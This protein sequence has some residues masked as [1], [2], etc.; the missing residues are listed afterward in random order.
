MSTEP[1]PV[2][3]TPEEAVA[4]LQAAAHVLDV[5]LLGYTTN[6]WES[7]VRL[8]R[9]L[10]RALRRAAQVDANLVTWLYLH[11]EHGKH[12]QVDGVSGTVAIG[13][14]RSKVRWEGP[15]AVRDYVAARITANDGEMPDPDTVIDWVLEVVPATPSTEL[16][17]TPL[18][19]A[20]LDPEDYS[21]SEPGTVSV[22]VLLDT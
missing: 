16:R 21:Q 3:V 4:R 2:D 17:K 7:A 9:D 15:D 20:G 14:G 22:S 11:G 18:R 10:R 12:L 8:L 6:D 5:A 1:E 13:R 19:E